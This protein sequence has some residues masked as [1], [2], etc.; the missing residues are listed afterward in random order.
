[1]KQFDLFAGFYEPAK[2]KGKTRNQG[3]PKIVTSEIVF[4]T[5]KLLSSKEKISNDE[6]M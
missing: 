3:R 5:K 4:E 6:I 2:S 1:M